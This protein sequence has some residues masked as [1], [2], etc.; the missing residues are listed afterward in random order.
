MGLLDNE[1][2][3]GYYQGNDYGNYQFTSL[4]DIINQFLIAY[5]GEEKIIS[6]VGRTDVAFHAQR[7][8]I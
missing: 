2:Q 4:K 6:K 3:V 5:V 7:I 8:I 1:T